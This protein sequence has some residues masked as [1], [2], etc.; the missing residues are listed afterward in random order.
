MISHDEIP[1]SYKYLLFGDEDEIENP[2]SIPDVIVEELPDDT[3]DTNDSESASY[4]VDV[5]TDNS[6]ADELDD[7]TSSQESDEEVSEG[8]D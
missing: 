2:E 5:D 7:D 8:S 1:D 6:S 4:V 3:T